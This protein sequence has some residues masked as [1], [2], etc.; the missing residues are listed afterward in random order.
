MTNDSLLDTR[1]QQK[2]EL[3]ITRSGN[4]LQVPEGAP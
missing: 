4:A 1:E 2:T 3:L